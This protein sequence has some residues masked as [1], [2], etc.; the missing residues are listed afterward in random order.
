MGK[1][2]LT[3]KELK[4]IERLQHLG[5][6]KYFV[7][8]GSILPFF[9]FWNAWRSLPQCRCTS[10]VMEVC[11]REIVGCRLEVIIDLGLSVFIIIIIISLWVY[12]STLRR[13]FNKLLD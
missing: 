1:D 7:L 10:E 12:A 2:K 4:F 6:D 11:L 8:L 13:I 9:L 3:E 5:F